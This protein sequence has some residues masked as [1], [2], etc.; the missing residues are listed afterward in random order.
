MLRRVLVAIAILAAPARA[1][2]YDPLSP[3]FD[4]VP[5]ISA[6]DGSGTVSSDI[7]LAGNYITDS[8]GMAQ[9]CGAQTT[10]HSL[11]TGDGGCIGDL[12]VDGIAY[13]DSAVQ[14]AGVMNV[15]ASVIMRYA[16]TSGGL[17]MGAGAQTITV[18]ALLLGTSGRHMLVMDYVDYTTDFGHTQQT[19]P[20]IFMQSSDET[21]IGQFNS[22]RWNRLALGGDGGGLGC[23]NETFAY[24]D[25]VDGGG[26]SGTFTMTEQ[27]PIGAVVQQAILHTLNPG[28]TG[29][30]SATIQF[31]DGTD[32]DRYNTGTPSVFTAA[33]GGV[34]LG[35]PSGTVHHT[36]AATVTVT[37]TTNADYTS[38]S[39]GQATVAICYWTP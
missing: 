20:T 33:A 34:Y 27:I 35:A 36:A 2:S 11:G 13:F 18:P 12:E 15:G 30:V 39:A 21:D 16:S 25:M 4:A 14:F 7:D 26:A 10:S 31:G 28:F 3:A 38:V 37:V 5:G 22:L 29:D 8:T 1:L 6:V 17:Q 32:V 23:I 24:D 19:D 9:L